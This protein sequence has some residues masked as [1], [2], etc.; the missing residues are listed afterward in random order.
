MCTLPQV[1]IHVDRDDVVSYMI[2][3]FTIMHDQPPGFQKYEPSTAAKDATMEDIKYAV[4]LLKAASHI[5]YDALVTSVSQHL[6][7]VYWASA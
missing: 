6:T 4:G 3:C 7:A 1:R 2:D 5:G